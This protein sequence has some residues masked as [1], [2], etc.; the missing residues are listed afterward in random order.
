[1]TIPDDT[2]VLVER[3][4][5]RSDALSRDAK[6][7]IEALTRD[8]AARENE[9]NEADARAD[10]LARWLDEARRDLA[11]E[12]A[13]REKAI[14][15]ANSIYQEWSRRYYGLIKVKEAAERR[16][17]Q[18]ERERD[19]ALAD[20]LRRNKD[21][22]DR[23]IDLGMALAHIAELEAVL[24]PLPDIL[25]GEGYLPQADKLEATLNG[26]AND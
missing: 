25:R 15:N 11:A 19:E 12:R 10:D 4:G 6:R 9:R 8:L 1:M 16:A 13:A 18:A 2:A 3:L 17:E 20:Y 7:A 24:R 23:A 5:M 22:A 21:A 26:A 14:G